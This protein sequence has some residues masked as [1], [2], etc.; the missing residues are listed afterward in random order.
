MIVCISMFLPKRRDTMCNNRSNKDIS[1]EYYSDINID[2]SNFQNKKQSHISTYIYS[3]HIS[4]KVSTL[5]ESKYE[6]A[7]KPC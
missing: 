1:L 2:N 6:Y 5:N 4:S 7:T 3:N